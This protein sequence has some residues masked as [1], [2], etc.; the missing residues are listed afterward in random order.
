MLEKFK[1][2][3]PIGRWADEKQAEPGQ[4]SSREGLNGYGQG[5]DS[6]FKRLGEA[7]LEDPALDR[8]WT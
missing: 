2:A 6:D 8:D 7:F 4:L 3:S 5:F 1:K